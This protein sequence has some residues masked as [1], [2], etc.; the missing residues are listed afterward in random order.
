MNKLRSPRTTTH[1]YLHT[2]VCNFPAL[3]IRQIVSDG[4]CANDD[5][6]DAARNFTLFSKI[7]RRQKKQ[8]ILIRRAGT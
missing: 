5:D 8:Q 4:N 6:D 7:K 1:K 2:F 3:N